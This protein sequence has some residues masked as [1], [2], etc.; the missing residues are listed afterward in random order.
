MGR[1]LALVGALIVAA[2]IG[3]TL[4]R[5]S[6]PQ[7]ASAPPGAFSAE[8]A[9]AD[10]AVIAREPHPIGSAANDRVRDYLVSRMTALGLSPQVRPGVGV[11]ASRW[12]ANL[13]V[14]GRVDNIVGVLP[15]RDRSA[16][17][18]ALMAHYD[19]VPASPGAADDAAGVATALEAVRAIQA[20]GTPARDVMVVITDG[21]EAGLL[22]ANAF[23][24]RDP[25][26]KR[27]GFL[28]NM[29]ARGS[30]GRVQMF[31]TGPQSGEAIGLLQK[32]ARRPQASSLS[33]F[34]YERM[35]NDTDFSESRKA[36]VAGLNFAFAGR[37]FDYHSPTST[38]ALQDHR[39]LQDMGDQVL[40]LAR[41]AA[42]APAL[43][44]PAPDLVYNQLFGDVILAYPPLAGWLL[45]LATA[46]LIAVGVRRARRID[47]FPWLDVAR[48]AGAALFATLGVAAVEHFA[49]RCTG[50][51]MGYFEQRFLLA[52]NERWETAAFLMGLG[53]LVWAAAELARGRRNVAIVPLVA[54]IASSAF[55]GFDKVGLILGVAAGL[56]GLVSYGRPVT[57]PG[58]WSGVLILGLVLSVG[59]QAYAPAAA[60]TF[61]WPLLLAAV[62][63]AA[64]A[65]ATR[66]GYRSLVMLALL[67]AIG[68]GWLAGVAHAGF[69]SLDMAELLA[70]SAFLAALLVWPLAQPEE[71]APPARLAGPALLAAGFVVLLA[72]RINTPWDARHPQVSYVAYKIDQDAGRAWRVSRAADRSAWSDQVLKADGGAVTQIEDWTLPGKMDA[73]PAAFLTEP[74]PEMTLTKQP[75]G[76][77]RLHAVPPPGARRFSLLLKPDTAAAVTAMAGVPVDTRLKPGG[78]LRVRWEG[79]RGP[80]ELVIRPGGPGRLEVRY[81][82]V[83][84]RWPAGAKP[85]PPRPKDLMPFDTSD[86][87][88]VTG[89]RRFAW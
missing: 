86:S 27:V 70:L 58:A 71:G 5:P 85:L 34:I 82:A 17:A 63:G 21:E 48:G 35:P 29:E 50:V 72:V 14:G 33:T 80:L 60:A 81:V 23:F 75:D 10:I 24:R 13:L 54:G 8:R 31:Q 62:G 36:G 38:P 78:D 12:A 26:A 51:A 44:K 32:N 15:G 56:V 11:Q 39:V 84:E 61:A 68:C 42:T 59:V 79:A 87:T 28:V 37:Q 41:A 47:P 1:L 46:G 6:P 22:G 77:L 52:Q 20:G 43:P 55:G 3:W 69:I 18:V 57:R 89:T 2:L 74:A 88:L 40:A 83:T 53:F 16:P 19:S 76:T 73:A 67:A 4:L 45:L 25:L 49:R 9:M 65:M 64:T 30:S 7:P 66:R